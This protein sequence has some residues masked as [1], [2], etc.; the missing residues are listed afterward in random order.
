[1]LCNQ[2]GF[3]NPVQN[4]YCGQ[5]GTRL[6]AGNGDMAESMPSVVGPV[7]SEFRRE[8][9]QQRIRLQRLEDEPAKRYSELATPMYADSA[10]IDAEPRAERTAVA[11]AAAD[12]SIAVEAPI[13]GP[14]F[15]GLGTTEAAGTEDLAYL[16]EDEPRPGKARKFAALIIVLAFAAFIAY[17][18][19][20]NPNWQTTIIGK[21]RM[22]QGKTGPSQANGAGQPPTNAPVPA[23]DQG[24]N[25]AVTPPAESAKTQQTN[26]AAVPPAEAHEP[27][28]A[29]G[30]NAANTE[31]PDDTA[32]A[33]AQSESQSSNAAAARTDSTG[34]PGEQEAADNKSDDESVPSAEPQS[35]AAIAKDRR[36]S[37][38]AKAVAQAEEP[39][40]DL[41]TKADKYLYGRGVS[42]D[43]KQ[44]L[45]YLRTAANDGNAT[46]RSKLGGLYA[47]GHCVPLDRAEA[48]NWFTLSR[49]AGKMNV[50]VERN[51]E[52]LWS[53]MTPEEKGRTL[54][55]PR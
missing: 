44:A 3:D 5:C 30:E 11:H 40:A 13:S 54:E 53:K 55:P 34:A 8:V 18:W 4:K 48:Y 52:I 9:E 37:K 7:S 27:N 24:Q 22:Y 26:P 19:K 21:V 41:V 50:W 6:N 17:E 35:T 28:A 47:T 2:C 12:E 46:A 43:C 45:V 32:P 31:K 15:L 51:R 16:Y 49:R 23:A 25:A 1:M 42:R 14:S 29:P 36:A 20:Q 38:P 33:P 10:S 39:G